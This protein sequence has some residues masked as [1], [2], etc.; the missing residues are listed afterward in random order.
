MANRIVT[1]LFLERPSFKEVSKVAQSLASGG[2]KS[3]V[4]PPEDRGINTHLIVESSD[5]P[6]ARKKFKELGMTAVE[7]EVVLIELEN[8][9]GTM[10]EVTNRI[11]SKGVNL[12]YAF[13]VAMNPK[14]S[15]VLFGGPDNPSILKALQ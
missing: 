8:R 6:K 4:M 5:L 10:A 11:S 1:E 15:Y 12:T 2:V 14:L 9:P 3:I 13:S 7:K